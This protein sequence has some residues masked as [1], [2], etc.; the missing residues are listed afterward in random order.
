MSLKVIALLVSI[1][2]PLSGCMSSQIGKSKAEIEQLY[3]T[4]L[5]LLSKTGDYQLIKVLVPHKTDR[6]LIIKGGQVVSEF[7]SRNLETALD[8]FKL[9]AK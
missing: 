6:F 5:L 4:K 9:M 7:K 3:S 1:L 2:C 8:S